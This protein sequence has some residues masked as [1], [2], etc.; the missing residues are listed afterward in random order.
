M[1]STTT[2]LPSFG[3]LLD[4][5][6]ESEAEIARNQ[7]RPQHRTPSPGQLAAQAS[8]L[9]VS[10][11]VSAAT[12]DHAHPFHKATTRKTRP[13]RYQPYH[14]AGPLGLTAEV[15]VQTTISRR[16]SFP[17]EDE[18]EDSAR[19]A[20]ICM[21]KRH[22]S[23]LLAEG[24]RTRPQLAMV[25]IPSAPPISS[26][27]RR[28]G[29]NYSPKSPSSPSSPEYSPS[30]SVSHPAPLTLPTLPSFN[31]KPLISPTS[32]YPYQPPSLP[33]LSPRSGVSVSLS[34][35]HHSRTHSRESSSGSIASMSSSMSVSTDDGRSL[36]ISSLSGGSLSRPYRTTTVSTSPPIRA[37]P[38]R[39]WTASGYRYPPPAQ[40]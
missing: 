7:R 27:L 25:T 16:S 33:S 32:T 13:G 2:S 20:N 38:Y 19:V 17:G 30:H 8:G 18:H 11:I 31:L 3:E 14:T 12:P 9:G 15:C 40:S 10:I 35:R 24:G 21:I 34:R 5:L 36:S 29:G 6:R 23:A 4:S 26:L 28:G 37:R 1:H 22:K 39:V